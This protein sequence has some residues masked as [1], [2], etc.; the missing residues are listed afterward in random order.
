LIVAENVNNNEELARLLQKF[1]TRNATDRNVQA[2]QREFYEHLQRDLDLHIKQVVNF[3]E[4]LAQ[5]ALQNAWVKIFVSAH[6]YDPQLS[7]VKTWAKMIGFQCA[8]DEL[9]RLYSRQKLIADIKPRPVQADDADDGAGDF[10]GYTCALPSAEDA[11]HAQQVERAIA[12]CIERLPHGRGPNY[13]LAMQLT[14]DDD[15][16][17]AEMKDILAA[18]SPQYTN[19]NAE[20]VR[21]WVRQAAARM[22]GCINEKLGLSGKGGAK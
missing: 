5:V 14:L 13:R 6:T 9:R 22:K 17:Y 1:S 19:L 3:N 15:L 12:E 10:D 8:K 21:G 16:S 20:Q 18:Q 2:A 11:L 7:S 4:D